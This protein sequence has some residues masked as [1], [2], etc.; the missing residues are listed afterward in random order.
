MFEITETAEI[1]NL[2]VALDF[3]RSL[4]ERGCR[5][6]LDDFGS[7]LSSFRYLKSL[8][9][10]YLK[11]DGELVREIANDPIQRE[12]VAA[13]HRI[14]ESMGIQTIGEWVENSEIARALADI[15]VDYAQG[16]AVGRP[17]PFSE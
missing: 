12:M 3:M 16:F 2:S 11:I 6:V 17:V 10:Q 9:V 5:F 7:G 15:G 8:E 14:G 13:I 4:R 1:S